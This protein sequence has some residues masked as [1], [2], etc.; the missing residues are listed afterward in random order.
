[1]DSAP[2][3]TH[4]RGAALLRDPYL[5]KGTG[6]SLAERRELGLEGLLPQQEESLELQV[7]RAWEAFSQL[8]A[9][10]VRHSFVEALR[11]SNQVLFHRFLADHL[12]AV[13]PIVYTLSLIHI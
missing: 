1:M 12:E 6:F 13:L 11:R 4:L 10:L 2:R 7:Q 9:D 3:R 8:K 5:N